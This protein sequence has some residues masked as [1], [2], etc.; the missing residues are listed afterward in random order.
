MMLRRSLSCVCLSMVLVGLGC[1]QNVSTV[2]EGEPEAAQP[3]AEQQEDDGPGAT[4]TQ[5]F[6]VDVA[7][8]S[9]A[10]AASCSAETGGEVSGASLKL[11]GDCKKLDKEKVHSS[12]EVTVKVP[13][14][15]ES[16]QYIAERLAV[17]AVE[18]IVEKA[19]GGE[20]PGIAEAIAAGKSLVI[21]IALNSRVF[22]FRKRVE[23]TMRFAYDDLS[24]CDRGEITGLCEVL[25][26][27]GMWKLGLT[28]DY[29]GSDS[30]K[31]VAFNRFQ[32]A[33][34]REVQSA[35]DTMVEGAKDCMKEFNEINLVFPA[36]SA[37]TGES[38]VKIAIDIDN[39]RKQELI[40]CIGKVTDKVT[41]IKP[42]IPAVGQR[43]AK[44]TGIKTFLLEVVCGPQT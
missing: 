3:A 24:I 33:F 28:C 40:K 42:R 13:G 43:C 23:H 11:T 14:L 44:N 37:M 39:D 18:K 32:T 19:A 20:I 41:V 27:S 15:Q 35:I 1:K 8:G 17:K 9:A 21:N 6:D 36:V 34:R 10:D 26:L 29:M 4:Y 22:D 31:D 38:P 25:R 5:E 2:K 12:L 30:S 7:K 16:A